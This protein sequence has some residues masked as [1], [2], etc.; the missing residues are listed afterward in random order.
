MK[1]RLALFWLAIVCLAAGSLAAKDCP[2]QGDAKEARIAALDRLKN[3]KALLPIDQSIT[4]SA[5]LKPGNDARRFSP[6]KAATITGYIAEVKPGGLE[7]CNCHAKDLA[8]RD[9]H[10]ALVANP[11][12]FG[13]ARRY[14]IVE[15]TP[16]SRKAG[17]DQAS[18]KSLLHK[19]VMVTGDI[20][21]DEEHTQNAENTHPGGKA[22]WRAT[23]VELHPVFAIAAA[24]Y[25]PS[26]DH[27]AP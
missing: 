6:A 27:G 24:I 19:K 18:L 17:I 25:N 7:S 12:D 3:R 2:P 15:V 21:F 4:L 23:C 9:T 26:T 14:V 20:F 8:H 11:K 1:I 5:I 10:I 13:N 22:N 16:R